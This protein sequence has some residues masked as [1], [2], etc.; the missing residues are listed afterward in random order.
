MYDTCCICAGVFLRKFVLRSNRLAVVHSISLGTM[1]TSSL[2]SLPEPG[3]EFRHKTA[4]ALACLWVGSL[5][6][7]LLGSFLVLGRSVDTLRAK[8]YRLVLC[9]S[10]H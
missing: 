1:D 8:M 3:R 2:G 5:V 9:I 4:V 10:S 6:S 7:S